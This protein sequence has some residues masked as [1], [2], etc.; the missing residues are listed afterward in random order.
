M[1]CFCPKLILIIYNLKNKLNAFSLLGIENDLTISSYSFRVVPLLAFALLLAGEFQPSGG[2]FFLDKGA[3]S[4]FIIF[5]FRLSESC[6]FV[7]WDEKTVD[8]WF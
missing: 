6:L 1:S 4:C 7:M 3:F 8:G 2:N 5:Y